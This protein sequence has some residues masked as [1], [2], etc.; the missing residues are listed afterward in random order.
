MRRSPRRLI[1]HEPLQFVLLALKGHLWTYLKAVAGLV[2]MLPDLP[3]DRA[4]VKRI[5]TRSDRDLLV[6]GPLIVRDDLAGHRL[7]LRAKTAYE[8]ALTAYWHFLRRTVLGP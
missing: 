4:F 2:A 5:R 6:S 1:V 7:M 3:R 8:G